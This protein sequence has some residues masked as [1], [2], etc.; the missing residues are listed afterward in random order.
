MPTL[1][2]IRHGETNYNIAGKFTGQQEAH[3]TEKGIEDAKKKST[4]I[5][6]KFDYI[7]RSPLIR[8]QETLEAII[9][10]GKAIIDYRITDTCLGEWEGKRQADIAP[11]LIN[12][13]KKGKYT[14]PGAESREVVIH[15]TCDFVEELFKK[16]KNER[17]FII[18][19]AAIIRAIQFKFLETYDTARVQNLQTVEINEQNYKYYLSNK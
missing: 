5:N 11:E 9:P 7:Y 16:Y 10:G 19:H 8:T 14:P 12:A 6:K 18:T 4:C 15:R 1:I 2:F 17:I 13:F 3:L